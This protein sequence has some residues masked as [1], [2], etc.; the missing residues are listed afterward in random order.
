MQASPLTSSQANFPDKRREKT[1]QNFP[2]S[3]GSWGN[4]VKSP[5]LNKVASPFL[6]TS[7][8]QMGPKLLRKFV[9]EMGPICFKESSFPKEFEPMCWETIFYVSMG[10]LGLFASC[11]Q[12]SS[13]NL[14]SLLERT[15]LWAKLSQA[16]MYP[17]GFECI[18]PQGIP[19]TQEAT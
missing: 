6:R 17:R 10:N 8:A 4:L 9:E 11:L 18:C 13:R 1:L 16:T 19:Y 14:G 5:F 12:V 7:S 15:M 3:Q 2:F